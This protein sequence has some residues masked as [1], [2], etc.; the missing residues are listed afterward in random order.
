MP[1][2]KKDH[3]KPLSAALNKLRNG[4]RN[5]KFLVVRSGPVVG[6]V[7]K[8]KP[9]SKKLQTQKLKVTPTLMPTVI[10]AVQADSMGYLQGGL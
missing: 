1:I 10:V 9:V 7:A 3:L 6:H 2:L 5:L 4:G 8:Q